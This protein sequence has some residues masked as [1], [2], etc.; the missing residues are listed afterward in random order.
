MW[1]DRAV[2]RVLRPG[3]AAFI[4]TKVVADT[5][6]FGPLHIIGYFVL[7]TLGEGGSWGE[8]KAKVQRDFV[9]TFA[10]ECAFWP[11]FQAVNFTKVPPHYQLLAVNCATILDSTFMSWCRSKDDWLAELLPGAAARLKELGLAG[12]QAPSGQ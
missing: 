12:P 6:V 7:M 10:A 8:A 5:A 2:M 3:S 9:P 4:G 1:L 11:A